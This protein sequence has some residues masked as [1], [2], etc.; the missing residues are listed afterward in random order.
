MATK[1][2][3]VYCRV[4]TDD[5]EAEGTSLHTQLEAC[6]AYCHRKGYELAH[7][8]SEA[9]SG[10]TLERPKLNELRQLVRASDINVLVVYCLDRLSRDP[11][12]GVILTE[13]L[14]KHGATLEAVTESV[15]SSD[16]G[17]LINYVRGYAAKLE[18]EKIRER[19]GRG[20]VERARRGK[21]P[22]G[23]GSR[24][25]GYTYA[26]G[27]GAGQGVRYVNEQEAE[28][29]REM[30]RWLVEERLSSE[31]ITKRLRGLSV[32]TPSGKG[33]WV[34]STVKNI[35][36][37]CAYCG[38]T[39]VFTGARVEPKFRLTPNP[40]RAKT[41]L[42]RKPVEEWL[43][44]PNC[45]PAIIS[46]ALFMAAQEQL[47]E[48]RRL[49]TRNCKTQYLLHG[50]VYC[51]RCGRAF[52]GSTGIK[53][54]GGKRY[55]YPCY[56]CS[57]KLKKVTPVKCPNKQHSAKWLEAVV[58]EQVEK[59]LTQPELVFSQVEDQRAKQHT[60][61]WERDLQTTALQL[62]N[63]EKQ[64]ERT[65]KA[66][67]ITGDEETF[68]RDIAALDK[69]I[70]ELRQERTRLE[71]QLQASREL[72]PDMSDIKKAC[73]LVAMN[74]HTLS[75]EDK[76]LALGALQVK[77]LADGDAITM[78]G[79]IPIPMGVSAATPS[80]SVHPRVGRF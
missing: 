75:Y 71:A 64:K 51:Q 37:N 66:F 68:R 7:S 62:R 28:R 9:K 55:E 57:G 78:K 31:A 63:R 35:L 12:H 23:A 27:K 49:G 26:P 73:E 69:S 54:R 22:S 17:K 25:Y 1:T 19:T 2:A 20:R 40:K 46:E 67:E 10:L 48:N 6:A 47:A 50:H 30:F 4:S 24:L 8:F 65:W 79:V 59:V 41:G 15:D 61:L 3:A 44:I 11:V 77:V 42:L 5:Q 53:T 14:E 34:S 80:L 70:Q 39:F 60:S 18:A 16:L 33:Y 36:K 21:L 38:R 76:R 43:E 58:W 52:W 74:L 45:T 13:E 56:R 29:V 32:P 72:N